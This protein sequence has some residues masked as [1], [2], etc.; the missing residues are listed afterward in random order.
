MLLLTWS[1]VAAVI[2]FIH[3]FYMH[4]CTFHVM[5]SPSSRDQYVPLYYY[6]HSQS[7]EVLISLL[8]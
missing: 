5:G 4:M 6:Y 1:L 2:L 7:E 3:V 8:D